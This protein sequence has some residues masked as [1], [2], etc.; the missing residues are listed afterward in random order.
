MVRTEVKDRGLVAIIEQWKILEDEPFAKI[1]ILKTA[2]KHK[3]NP[4]RPKSPK[5]VTVVVIAVTLEFGSDKKNI[6]EWAFMRATVREMKLKWQILTRDFIKRIY[7]GQIT[8]EDALGLMA[9]EIKA[10]IQKKIIEIDTPPNS[11]VTIRIKKSSN[12]LVDSGQM[13]QT[14]DFKVFIK[15]IGD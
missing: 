4:D 13:G 3:G 2:G 10:D 12:P 14:I 11:E 9:A 6:P 7:R 8:V 15:G 1:G 5:P